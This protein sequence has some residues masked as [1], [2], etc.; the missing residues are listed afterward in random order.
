MEQMSAFSLYRTLL[1]VTE[2]KFN[3]YFRLTFHKLIGKDKFMANQNNAL[4]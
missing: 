1:A 3:L 4:F 2:S